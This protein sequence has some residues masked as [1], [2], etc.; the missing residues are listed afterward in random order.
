MDIV[1]KDS[2]IVIKSKDFQK[3]TDNAKKLLVSR[4]DLRR[5]KTMNMNFKRK[6]PIP[7]EIKIPYS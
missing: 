1:L 3:A 5:N 2:K 7:M 4:S 6:L